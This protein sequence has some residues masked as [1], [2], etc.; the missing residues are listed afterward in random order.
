MDKALN[1]KAQLIAS[2]TPEACSQLRKLH[3]KNTQHWETQLPENAK[4]T[5]HLALSDYSQNF[6]KSIK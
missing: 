1:Q 6:M 5:A 3:W 2:Y 4:I